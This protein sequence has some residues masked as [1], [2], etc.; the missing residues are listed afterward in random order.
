MAIYG[1]SMKQ[2]LNTRSS[3]EAELAAVHD[4]LP[5][6]LWTRQSLSGQGFRDTDPVIYQDNQSV[7]LLEKQGRG[8]SAR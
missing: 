7:M 3:T 1:S 6:I 4:T 2:I 8:S 5:Q